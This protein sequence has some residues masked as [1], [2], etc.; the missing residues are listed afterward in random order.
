M[1]RERKGNLTTTLKD[2]KKA[3]KTREWM[4]VPKKLTQNSMMACRM[5]SGRQS[6]ESPEIPIL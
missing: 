2:K 5:Q 1:R 6:L 4:N 3:E